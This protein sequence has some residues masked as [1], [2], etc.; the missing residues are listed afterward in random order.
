MVGTIVH[1]DGGVH[2]RAPLAQDPHRRRVAVVARDAERRLAP[3]R[4]GVDGHPE[5]AEDVH[6]RPNS[7][8]NEDFEEV[9]M[10]T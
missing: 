1:R 5:L 10:Y 4:R 6:D 7:Q 2:V 8:R 3:G 9:W